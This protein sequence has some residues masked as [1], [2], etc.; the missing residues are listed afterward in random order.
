MKSSSSESPLPEKSK[1]LKHFSEVF[2][3]II[4]EPFFPNPPGFDILFDSTLSKNPF[5]FQNDF[6]KQQISHLQ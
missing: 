2:V 1:T 6:S 3:M 5:K 4:L